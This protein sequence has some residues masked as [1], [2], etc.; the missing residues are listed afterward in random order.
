MSDE[1]NLSAEQP[2]GSPEIPEWVPEKFRSNPE[3]FGKSY[4]ELESKL[5]Q[6]SQALREQQEQF[7]AF[8]SQQ[9]E[10]RQ[11]QQWQAQAPQYENQLQAAY[12]ENPLAVMSWL[13]N[14]AAAQ[15]VQQSSR[16]PDEGFYSLVAD[17]AE[18]QLT[19]KY[20]DWQEY[21][22]RV[23][24][25]IQQRQDIYPEQLFHTPAGTVQALDEV[26]KVLKYEDVSSG[27][28]TLQQQSDEE[29]RHAKQQ[30]QT[31]SGAA[32]RPPATDSWEDKWAAIA[33]AGATSFR[34]I[35]SGQ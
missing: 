5:T 4:E 6:T 23:A 18:R 8:L 16:Q 32:G 14:Q 19:A 17:A 34:D 20:D 31:L 33:N 15:A 10:E 30:A 3:Q 7:E 28:A 21:A 1:Q 26:Y 2:E 22:P 29:Q 27:A 11:Q 35:V 25:R 9:D 24:E 13:A 12:E